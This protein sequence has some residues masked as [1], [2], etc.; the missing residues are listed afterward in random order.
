[1]SPELARSLLQDLPALEQ[2]WI[3]TAEA[4]LLARHAVERWQDIKRNGQAMHE[5]ILDE[6]TAA[7]GLFYGCSERDFKQDK[8]RLGWGDLLDGSR[9]MGS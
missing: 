1:L 3:P 8:A 9:P 5:L 2:I 4:L 6:F 7:D